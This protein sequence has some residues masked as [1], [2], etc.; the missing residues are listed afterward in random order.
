MVFGVENKFWA[1]FTDGQPRKYRSTL[2]GFVQDDESRCLIVVI[3]PRA[4]INDVVKHVSTQ[5][6]EELTTIVLWEDVLDDLTKLSCERPEV[7]AAASFLHHYVKRQLES[8]I[9]LDPSYVVGS[10]VRIGNDFHYDF[11]SKMKGCFP[12]TERI[13][14]AKSWIGFHFRFTDDSTPDQTLASLKQ[15]F[16]FYGNGGNVT[17]GIHATV[18][19]LRLPGLQCFPSPW[20]N[21]TFIQIGYEKRTTREWSH[22][23]SPVLDELK[24]AVERAGPQ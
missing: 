6:I 4:R 7:A 20:S 1:D 12:N 8:D 11:L 23:L 2:K 9:P 3:C 17:M 19:N 24:I 10:Q 13:C 14:P 22:R 15:W 16:G 18:P 21:G 5:S